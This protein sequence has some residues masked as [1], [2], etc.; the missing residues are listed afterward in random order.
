[1]VLASDLGSRPLSGPLRTGGDP[2]SEDST[3]EV[4]HEYQ[5]GPLGREEKNQE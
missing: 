4:L 2:N 1:M 3:K 5:I